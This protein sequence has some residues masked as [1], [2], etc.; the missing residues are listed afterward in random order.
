MQTKLQYFI[1]VFSEIFTPKEYKLIKLSREEENIIGKDK[2]QCN[3]FLEIPNISDKHVK[4]I[5]EGENISF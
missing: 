1:K 4:I 5:I 3:V 2:D